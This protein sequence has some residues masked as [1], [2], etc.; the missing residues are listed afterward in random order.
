MAKTLCAASA[1]ECLFVDFLS[2]EKPKKVSKALKHPRW[3]DAMQDELNQ[4]ARNKVWTLVPAPYGKTIIRSKW[5]FR[6]KRD[7][8]RIVIKNKARLAAQGCNHQEGID[9][10]DTFTPVARLE[11]IRIFLAFATYINFIVYQMDVKSAFL[12]GKLKEQVYVKQPPG[13]ES[14]E[15][16]NHVCKLDKALYGFKQ[17][18]RARYG[19]LLTYLTDHKFVKGKIDNTLFVYK[20]QTDVIMV[21]I[22]VD[23][24]IF[25]ST[26]TKLFKKFA[27]LINQIYEMSMMGVLTYFLGFQIKQSER[28]ILIN[29]EKYVK[30]LLKKYDINGSSVQTLMVPPNNLG[31]DLNGKSVNE[32]RFRGMIGSLM[33]L[34]ASRPDIQF[35]TCLCVRYQANPK[36]KS[37][38]GACQLLGGKLL[39]WSAKKKQSIAMS[40]AKAEY[41]AA[42]GCYANISWM[43]SQLTDYDIIYEQKLTGTRSLDYLSS[44]GLKICSDSE[45]QFEEEETEAMGEPTMEEY[46]TKTREDY[47]SRPKIDEKAHFK[48]KGQFLKELH[49]NTFSRS[50][51]KDAN[52]HIEK[53]LENVDLFHIPKPKLL[54]KRMEE[55]NNFQQEPDETLYQA[56]E[57]FKELTRSTGT[58]DGLAAIQAQL[59][60]LGREIKKGEG[61]TFEEAYYTQFGVPYPQGGRYRATALGFYQRDNVNP[62]Y[63]ERIQSMEESLSKFMDEYAKI[64]DEN[65]NLIKE[66]RAATDAV[67]Q[68]Q[69]ASI[70]ALEIQIR[71]IDIDVLDSTTYLKKMLKERP[72]M[73]YQIETSINMNDSVVL[74]DSLPPKE[75]DPGS[76]GELAPTKVA[77]EL[78]DRTIKHPKGIAENVLVGIGSFFPIDFIVLDMPEDIKVPLILGRPFLSIAHAKINVLR[79]SLDPNFRDF[80]KLN[81]LNE[82]L[83]LIRNQVE[84]LGPTI[85]G[86]EVIDKPMV[87]I[88]ETRND[89]GKIVESMDPYHDQEM[90]DG[91]MENH[92]VE[93]SV[94][95]QGGSMEL[96]PFTMGFDQMVSKTWN[97]IDLDDNNKMVRFKK[98]LQILKKEIRSWV[99]DCKKNQSGRLVDL[100]SK[101]CH[102][103]KVID[104]GGVNDDIILTRLDLLK[105]LHDIKSSDARDYMQK[106]KIQWAIEGDENSKKFHGIINRK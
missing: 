12:N 2:E 24:I 6:N 9:Y 10:D 82:P 97:N 104:Q 85:E 68:N 37:T 100:R 49:D 56:W 57:P 1:Q 58:S 23:D 36:E 3:V 70:K 106:A 26:S 91:L 8:T 46:M 76:L 98:K 39:C 21:Q 43:K 90:G 95:R 93:K 16:P 41:V 50:D 35:L 14:N 32:T 5:V 62:S 25:G 92:F 73:G 55:I 105:K 84:D 42:A 75:K 99:N 96:L 34:T 87:D 40:L 94:S 69:G 88:I 72:K 60:N 28:G 80:I 20:T 101:L 54:I 63:Q 33:Y 102:I 78:A 53:V 61:K 48:L 17:A 59:N 15:F 103:D 65:S 71:Q 27:K 83:E 44:L 29:Q 86:G 81:D 31:P 30:D 38:S 74:E 18:L 52:E 13:F 89:D 77:V 7:D 47:R 11:A 66:I 4:F 19:T 45:D 67:I 22:Y 64:H 79:G 51:N